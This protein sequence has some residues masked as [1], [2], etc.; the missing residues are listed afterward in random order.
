MPWPTKY[1]NWK[2]DISHNKIKYS[3]RR[4]RKKCYFIWTFRDEKI[5]GEVGI[6]DEQTK[7]EQ[8]KEIADYSRRRV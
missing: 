2:G 6:K 7:K 4:S 8:R 5:V 1:N 3:I